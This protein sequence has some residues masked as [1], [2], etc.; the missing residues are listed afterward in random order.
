MR[1]L[2]AVIDWFENSPSYIHAIPHGL[3]FFFLTCG[4]TPRWE[5]NF[6]ATL[7]LLV[8]WWMVFVAAFTWAA[9]EKTQPEQ[10]T[11]GEGGSPGS[12]QTIVFYASCVLVG[13]F[14][15]ASLWV[16]GKH[17][18]TH[19][20]KWTEADLGFWFP[21]LWQ[22]LAVVM[23]GIA[24]LGRWWA[25]D[26]SLEVEKEY[27][28]FSAIKFPEGITQP[29]NTPSKHLF[30]VLL[31][32][33]PAVLTVAPLE[34]LFP[35]AAWVVFADG[36]WLSFIPATYFS[37]FYSVTVIALLVSAWIV[38]ACEQEEM[39]RGSFAQAKVCSRLMSQVRALFFKGGL[40]TTSVIVVLLAA[41]WHCRFDYVRTVMEVDR[42]VVVW[43]LLALY[44]LFW[45]WEWWVGTAVTQQLVG[46]LNNGNK[47]K[48]M[49]GNIEKEQS[50]PGVIMRAEIQGSSRIKL[51]CQSRN[52]KTVDNADRRE[53]F[54]RLFKRFELNPKD[55][56][57]FSH[58]LKQRVQRHFV[59]LQALLT[60]F[61]LCLGV[62]WYQHE[63]EPTLAAASA[64]PEDRTK[65]RDL[66]TLIAPY[67]E[68]KSASPTS[69]ASSETETTPPQRPK[70]VLIA[71]SGGGTR[72]ALFT[73]SAL[74][75]LQKIGCLKHV[76]LVSGVSGGGVALAY[77]AAHEKDLRGNDTRSG[78]WKSFHERMAY[79]YIIDVLRGGTEPRILW[80]TSIGTLLAESLKRQFEDDFV[81]AP[82]KFGCVPFGVILN[83]TLCGEAPADFNGKNRQRPLL[84]I[85]APDFAA[86]N[87]A[88]GRL[89]FTNLCDAKAFPHCGPPHAP[90]EFLKYVVV[91]DPQIE[92]AR[93][94]A[95]NAN[96]PPV[97]PNAPVEVCCEQGTSRYW[98]SDGGV[99]ENK[100]E[101]SL[102]YALEHAL[103]AL[104]KRECPP[105]KKQPILPDIHLVV[106][107]A[108]AA[109]VIYTQDFGVGA[110]GNAGTKLANQLALEL[111]RRI[112]ATYQLLGKSEL[113]DQKLRDRGAAEKLAPPKFCVHFLPMPSV[114]R[115]NGLGT[116]WALPEKVI[117]H[118]TAV[119]GERKPGE[120][121]EL[122]KEQIQCVI[123]LLHPADPDHPPSHKNCQ[124]QQV[125]DWIRDDPLAKHPD[126][127]KEL[128]KALTCQPKP[129]AAN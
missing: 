108:S 21:S 14:F 20:P 83:T 28:M 128:V 103:L 113:T 104:A 26:I 52:Q 101:I 118:P 127:W 62:V 31:E 98:V 7:F 45:T 46:L 33:T 91:Q 53:V 90:R 38:L 34:L 58:A 125:L 112:T 82:A 17:F 93:A 129:K 40:W 2:I 94:A 105:D 36:R 76:Q 78:F 41:A 67:E 27:P 121:V 87:N 51:T 64:K 75:G 124:I 100:G 86:A 122:T 117:V 109:N 71:A 123:K 32:N 92:L 18:N 116:H 47:D 6:A 49:I 57:S 9:R 55:F 44:S 56:E 12:R 42:S 5:G 54:D 102:L 72:A 68:S 11:H 89:I 65:L 10:S 37:V 19:T 70:V 120:T 8:G 95:L 24:A 48:A 115:V 3:L 4:P 79:P 106:I 23:F 111:E 88:A 16:A 66:T 74:D 25:S 96:F 85:R 77:L 110:A 126:H 60:V 114:L 80:Q 35:T 59:T 50:R 43:F 1:S 22:L 119:P 99:E 73:A 97:F 13:L 15:L 39:S 84:P 61:F 63:R 30:T 69:A 81:P 29:N 107:E